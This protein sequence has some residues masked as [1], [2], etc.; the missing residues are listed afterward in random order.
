VRFGVGATAHG[1]KRNRT[2]SPCSGKRVSRSR[3]GS[4]IAKR[5]RRSLRPLNEG[6]RQ[7]LPHLLQRAVLQHEA[8]KQR[9]S[10][11][12]I[13][14]AASANS[15]PTWSKKNRGAHS[16]CHVKPLSLQPNV[17]IGHV[18]GETRCR[19]LIDCSDLYRPARP[20][21]S[22]TR[23][24]RLFHSAFNSLPSV[25]RSS[26]GSLAPPHAAFFPRRALRR[27]ALASTRPVTHKH[28]GNAAAQ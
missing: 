7:S 13:C 24:Y 12:A 9:R 22:S 25:S 21:A 2:T 28:T 1:R 16:P 14:L 6:T 3:R 26:N 23:A 17:S 11:A 19:P 10:A 4:A 5:Q 15:P 8:V 27:Y 18:C 20:D